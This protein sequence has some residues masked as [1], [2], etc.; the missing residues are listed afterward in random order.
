MGTCL[1]VWQKQVRP[2]SKRPAWWRF[3][4]GLFSYI[5][6]VGVRSDGTGVA[7]G[8]GDDVGVSEGVTEGSGFAVASIVASGV[9][10]GL[11]DSP[12]MD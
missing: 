10:D 6:G 5:D 7:D 1:V 4:V 12:G 2:E 11:T 3:D 9:A 8:S